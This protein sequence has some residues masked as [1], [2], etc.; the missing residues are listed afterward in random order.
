MA[1]CMTNKKYNITVFTNICTRRSD[2][3]FSTTAI[4]DIVLHAL[5]FLRIAPTSDLATGS[6][7][8]GARMRPMNYSPLVIEIYVVW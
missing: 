6:L 3:T 2:G 4:L 7:V 8:G 5:A 1:L